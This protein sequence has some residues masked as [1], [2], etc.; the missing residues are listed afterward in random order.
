ML[1]FGAKAAWGH[2][3]SEIS[4]DESEM[5]P[6]FS[7]PVGRAQLFW[8]GRL[9]REANLMNTFMRNNSWDEHFGTNK[10]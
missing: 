3:A 5:C 8:L 4:D 2:H 7:M 10:S 6:N 1:A 9:L